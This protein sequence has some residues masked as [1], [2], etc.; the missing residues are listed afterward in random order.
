MASEDI[1]LLARMRIEKPNNATVTLHVRK[2][3]RRHF[4]PVHDF[5]RTR[6]IIHRLMFF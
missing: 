2:I 3:F 6:E 4:G 1:L 5:M